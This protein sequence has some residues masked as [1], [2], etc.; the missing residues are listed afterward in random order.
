MS[1]C[2]TFNFQILGC[3]NVFE[4]MS[5]T[6]ISEPWAAEPWVLGVNS[7]KHHCMLAIVL[8]L[9]LGICC[10]SLPVTGYWGRWTFWS[11]SACLLLWT[12][13]E[14]MLLIWWVHSKP[15]YTSKSQNLKAWQYGYHRKAFL[16][17]FQQR[18]AGKTKTILFPVPSSLLV[19]RELLS[20]INTFYHYLYFPLRNGVKRYSK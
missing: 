18:L 6:D 4:W 5:H 8:H 11:D 1:L 10:W 15:D 14:V 16:K 9:S 2:F 13:K 3:Q 17:R 12:K 7:G 20:R 19:P